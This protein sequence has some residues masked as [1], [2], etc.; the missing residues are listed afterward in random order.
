M[1]E[2][3]FKFQVFKNG[4]FFW[5]CFFMHAKSKRPAQFLNFFEFSD[6]LVLTMYGPLSNLVSLFL[7]PRI[8]INKTSLNKA[9]FDIDSL[10][11]KEKRLFCFLVMNNTLVM[12]FF[13][14][15][16]NSFILS[17]PFGYTFQH[18]NING[19]K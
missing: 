17:S 4:G 18:K 15:K 9:H 10:Q 19:L 6:R 12:S 8:L 7:P 16:K 1:E 3:L 5:S 13:S 11:P 14:C 2:E